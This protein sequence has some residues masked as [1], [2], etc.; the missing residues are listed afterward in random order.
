MEQE[1]L[2]GLPGARVKVTGLKTKTGLPGVEFLEYEMPAAGRPIPPDTSPTDLWHWHVT[3][4]VPDTKAAASVLCGRASCVANGGVA[5]PDG[6]LGFTQG[7]LIRD[8]D[9]H[10]LQLVSR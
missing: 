1:H 9:G 2:D 8:P 7:F 3:V 10:A 6:A 4:M 5:M